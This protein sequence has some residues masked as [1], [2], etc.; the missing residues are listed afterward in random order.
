MHGSAMPAPEKID[1]NRK[2]CPL[3]GV[4]AVLGFSEKRRH[5]HCVASNDGDGRMLK[6]HQREKEPVRYDIRGA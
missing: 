3:H 2:I 6:M 1:T 5:I 4:Y